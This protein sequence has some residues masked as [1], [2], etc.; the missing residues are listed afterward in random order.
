MLPPR[1]RVVAYEVL[2]GGGDPA[3]L[4]AG[5][6]TG[7][8]P[9]GEQRI[10]A[11]ALEATAA[12]RSPHHVDGRPEQDIDA[13]APGL[14]GQLAG[15]GRYQLRVPGGAE[16]R[17]A[18]EAGGRDALIHRRPAYPGRAVGYGQ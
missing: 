16:R 6:V 4:Q 13:L 11:E 10:L 3:V 17:R 8:D 7:C 9:R 14:T 5:D 12:E 1:L 18:R 2:E 15:H